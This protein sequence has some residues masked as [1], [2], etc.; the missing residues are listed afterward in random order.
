MAKTKLV[1]LEEL[2]LGHSDQIL[3]LEGHL[4]SSSMS[5][6]EQLACF[7]QDLD[8]MSQDLE[9]RVTRSRLEIETVVE[10]LKGELGK[11]RKEDRQEQEGRLRSVK[12]VNN[13]KVFLTSNTYISNNQSFN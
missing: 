12:I 13:W 1:R 7:E 5:L 11:A 6:G 4:G 8:Q 2:T 9:K 10:R 3:T